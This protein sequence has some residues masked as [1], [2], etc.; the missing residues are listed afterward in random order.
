MTAVA[1]KVLLDDTT[2]VVGL[3]RGCEFTCSTVM[4][5]AP[6]C[7]VVRSTSANVHVKLA[8]RSA[9]GRA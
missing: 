7:G 9:L 8:Q 1:I 3:S 6:G 4:F 5:P 2:L